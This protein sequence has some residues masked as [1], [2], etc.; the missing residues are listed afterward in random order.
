M[1]R[2]RCILTSLI[3]MIT[4]SRASSLVT[5]TLV[6]TCPC[7][8]RPSAFWNGPSRSTRSRSSYVQNESFLTPHAHRTI[9]AVSHPES[10]FNHTDLSSKSLSRS[11][12]ENIETTITDTKSKP[13]ISNPTFDLP[14][15]IAF[16][17]DGNS[18]WSRQKSLPGSMGHVAGADR[19][20]HL[21]K[22][23]QQSPASSSTSVQP[24][25]PLERESEQNEFQRIEYCT[26]F[27][28]STENWSRPSTEISTLFKIMRRMA[29]QYQQN[30]AVREGKVQ[31][32]LLGNLDDERIPE[33]TR[34]E[35]RV[36][37]MNSKNACSRRKEDN[38][39]NI[40]TICLA[41]NYG[42]RADI[43]QATKKLAQSIASGE[44]SPDAIEDESEISKRLCTAHLPDPDLIIR[45]GGEKRL[46]N[47]LLWDAAYAELYF[48]DML[49]PDFDERALEEALVWYGKRKRR[50]G[51]RND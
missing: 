21:I 12:L 30:E 20:V 31:I 38:G 34:K 37:E 14:R 45:T 5:T 32:E 48:S 50:F 3:W 9:T 27:A 40:L 35:L 11:V 39:H 51:G 36:L 42:G 28:F 8:Y 1:P 6:P 17:C 22:A 10:A 4:S 46:S 23:L 18:R 7:R 16:I 24:K 41:I 47:F 15:H 44:L 33:A 2:I 19:V 13:I 43:L 29:I 25:Q 49:W 26:L